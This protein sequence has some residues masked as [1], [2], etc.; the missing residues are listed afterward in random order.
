MDKEQNMYRQLLA[1]ALGRLNEQQQA[2]LVEELGWDTKAGE[3]LRDVL[4]H[5]L[6]WQEQPLSMEELQKELKRELQG[7]NVVRREFYQ[8]LTRLI[9]RMQ[10]TDAQVYNK[11]G[12]S[13]S[14]WYHIRDKKNAR[15]KKENVLRM[16]VVLHVDYWEMYYLVNLAGYSLLP[17]QNGTDRIIT[18]CIRTKIYDTAKI[19]VLLIENGEPPLFSEE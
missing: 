7:K 19:D 16:A 1:A 14:L 15:T 3:A 12:M 6:H 11:I 18:A 9:D 2:A 4:V 13:R 8:E 10:M 17:G 5:D